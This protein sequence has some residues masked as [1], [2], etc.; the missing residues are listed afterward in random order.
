MPENQGELRT[1][2][3]VLRDIGWNE[4]VLKK[5]S[6]HAD[7]GIIGDKKDLT[8]RKNSFG[9]NVPTYPA[10]RPYGKILLTQFE[11]TWVQALLVLSLVAFICSFFTKDDPY[12]WM[13]GPTIVCVLLIAGLVQ[14][15]CDYVR[16]KQIVR[17]CTEIQREKSNVLRGQYGVATTVLAEDLVI[18]DVLCL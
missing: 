13:I 10:I 18:G 16:E 9:T 6:T 11:D 7:T 15:L 14:S 1:C 8:R 5:L 3:R 4:G 12:A 17:L 2:N